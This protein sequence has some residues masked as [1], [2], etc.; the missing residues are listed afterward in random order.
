MVVLEDSD[1]GEIGAPQVVVSRSIVPP[2]TPFVKLPERDK[3]A[4]KVLTEGYII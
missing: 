1:R 4:G 2:Y 3:I